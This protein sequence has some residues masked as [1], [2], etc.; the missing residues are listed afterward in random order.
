MSFIQTWGSVIGPVMAGAI[1]DS[2]ASYNSLLWIM[3]GIL[4]VAGCFYAMV[5]K[6]ALRGKNSRIKDRG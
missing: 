2:T 3:V 6:P 1:Y 5:A 4:L